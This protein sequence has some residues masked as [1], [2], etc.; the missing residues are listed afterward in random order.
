[1]DGPTAD[2]MWAFLPIGYLQTILIEFPILWFGLSSRHSRGTRVAAGLWLTACTYPVVI[3]V[4]P[5][6]V[7]QWYG[8]EAYLL[9]AETFAPVAEV[10]LFRL[11]F[12][13]PTSPAEDSQRDGL[14]DAAV[15]VAA[16]LASF[17]LGLGLQ[18]LGIF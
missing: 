17:L 18:E 10:L 2:E 3:L 14:R 7:W 4:L 12:S 9:V 1:M 16:N 6:T 13:N 8:Y 11:L 15:I 5:L